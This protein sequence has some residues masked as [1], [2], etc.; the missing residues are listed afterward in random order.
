MHLQPASNTGPPLASSYA[1]NLFQSA[2]QVSLPIWTKEQFLIQIYSQYFLVLI[3]CKLTLGTCEVKQ[4]LLIFREP[5]I[6]Y[7]IMLV[8]N[9]MR[10]IKVRCI[11]GRNMYCTKMIIWPNLSIKIGNHPHRAPFQNPLFS[12]I[13]RKKPQMITGALEY[14]G[15]W[16]PLLPNN[17]LWSFILLCLNSFLATFANI[18]ELL[19]QFLEEGAKNEESGPQPLTTTQ[20]LASPKWKE[21]Q[22]NLM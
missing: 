13:H 19:F 1:Y 6:Y 17:A 7:L 4:K 5:P 10:M 3:Q 21:E 16:N 11:M 15:S 14:L 9:W 18:W 12:W 8:Y 2:M 20:N 22:Q